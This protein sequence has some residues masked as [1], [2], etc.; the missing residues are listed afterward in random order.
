MCN[1]MKLKLHFDQQK[2]RVANQSVQVSLSIQYIR[3]RW[4][5]Q[6]KRMP[7]QITDIAERWLQVYVDHFIV[8]LETTAAM[9][10][11]TQ[12]FATYTGSLMFPFIFFTFSHLMYVSFVDSF[13][14]TTT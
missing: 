2:T 3:R 1:V 6:F 12:Y 13:S 9:C 5:L 8:A 14:A 4:C 7:L 10:G 11:Q